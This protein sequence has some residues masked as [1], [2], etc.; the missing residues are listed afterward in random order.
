LSRERDQRQTPG[1]S[2]AF[3]RDDC[4]VEALPGFS[5]PDVNH[6]GFSQAVLSAHAVRAPE[7]L[8]KTEAALEQRGSVTEGAFDGLPE[9]HARTDEGDGARARGPFS[10]SL[11]VAEVIEDA[12]IQERD[13]YVTKLVEVPAESN[14]F[15]MKDEVSPDKFERDPD[16]DGEQN[17]DKISEEALNKG[18]ER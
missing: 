14:F 13:D 11:P 18:S 16:C 8:E 9:S 2:T 7:V 5:F 4:D 10:G 15:F 12:E 6:D 17:V 3:A 1:P